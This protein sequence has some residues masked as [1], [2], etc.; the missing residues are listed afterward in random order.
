[1]YSCCDGI[2]T[3]Y[4]PYLRQ[5]WSLTGGNVIV[6]NSKAEWDA[7]ISG[8]AN[9]GKAVRNTMANEHRSPFLFSKT[10][11]P[12]IVRSPPLSPFPLH[13]HTQII[14]DFTA[15]WCGPCRMI[16]PV[17]EE[18]STKHSGVVFLKVDVDAVSDVAGACGIAAMPTFHVYK[19]GQKVDELVG[20][21]KDR[22]I[23]LIAKYS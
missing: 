7:Q 18:L 17:F 4:V 1:M 10:L 19:D 23:A 11:P 21:S 3:S 15:T 9:A 12:L 16:G 13:T 14:V 20:A 22:L 6:I 2:L 8:G 5:F